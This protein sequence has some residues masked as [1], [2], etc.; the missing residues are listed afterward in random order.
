MAN[1]LGGDFSSFE[2]TPEELAEEIPRKKK[3]NGIDGVEPPW[4]EPDMGVL[5]LH[6][7]PPPPFPIKVLGPAWGR[8]TNNAADA[9]ACPIDYVVAPLLASVSVLIGHARWAQATPGW[10]E[11][12][13]LWVGAVGDSGDG[14]HREPIVCCAMCCRSWNSAWS[15]TSRIAF[16]SGEP[17]KNL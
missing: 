2:R 6:R 12:P 10:S 5:R 7:R 17:S 4:G 13:H 14:N 16:V 3:P 1:G 8:W 15:L 9:A 11:P